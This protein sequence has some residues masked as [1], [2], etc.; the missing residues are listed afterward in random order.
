MGNCPFYLE[1]YPFK[2]YLIRFIFLE[3]ES[4]SGSEDEDDGDGAGDRRVD[5]E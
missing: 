1:H 3:G 2:I 5:G 4:D